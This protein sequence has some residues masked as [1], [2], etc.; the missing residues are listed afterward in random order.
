MIAV[1]GACGFIGSVLVKTLND[2]G[3]DDL[4]LVDDFQIDDRLGFAYNPNYRYLQSKK[5]KKI[6]NINF[7]TDNIFKD[8]KIDFIFH[9]GAISDTTEH[10]YVKINRYN[11]EYTRL[12]SNYASCKRVPVV[13]AST[14]AVYGNGYGPLN[15]YAKS[16]L[17]C[18]S[19]L[20]DV[21]CCFRIFN[22]YGPNEYHKNHMSS[23]I[24]KWQRES[25]T[26][27]SIKLFENSSS[28][29][30]DFIYVED[31][32]SVM[33]KCFNKYMTGVFDLGTGNQ[34]SFENLADSFLSINGG[35]KDYI[36][37]PANIVNQYQTNTVANKHDLEDSGWSID[38][39]SID[40]GVSKYLSYINNNEQVI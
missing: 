10:D 9:L 4:L 38:F 18:E 29:F 28:Y 34:L 22:V 8:N 30:R 1:T 21:A 39:L 14:A 33:L 24:L 6:C 11:T 2:S 12:I 13:F 23:V 26:D 3:I 27:N 37:M 15:L 35:V 17:E 19:I 32:C 36:G 31:V 7:E 40:E 25:K 5:F 16:K 20:K